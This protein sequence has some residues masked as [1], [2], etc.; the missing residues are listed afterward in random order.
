MKNLLTS[1]AAFTAL[2]AAAT[3]VDLPL[4]PAPPVV[5][6]LRGFTWPGAYFGINAGYGFD[7]GNDSNRYNLPAGSV[8]NSGA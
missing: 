5:W 6:P 3:A 8:L 2:P 1:F 4:R 7:A